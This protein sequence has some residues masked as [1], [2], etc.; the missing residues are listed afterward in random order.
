MNLPK[1][2][3]KNVFFVSLSIIKYRLRIFF[4]FLLL[5]CLKFSAQSQSGSTIYRN[6]CSGCHGNALQGSSA[7]A[8]IKKNWKHGGE[9]NSI[10]KSISNGI[11][12]TEMA[13]FST[14][15]S[16]RQIETVTNY[17][18][19]LQNKTSKAVPA[20]KSLLLNTK[21]YQLKV[22]KLVT[23]GIKTPMAI[24]FVDSNRALIAGYKGEMRW[25]VNGK[26][27]QTPITGLPKTYGVKLVGG[28]L[29][30]ALDPGYSKNGWIY[31]SFAHNNSNSTNKNTP[32]MTKIVRGR[33]HNYKW[34]D[35]QTLFDV[36][37]SL[38]VPNGGVLWGSRFLFDTQGF[39]YFSIGDMNRPDDS[40]ILSKPS[41]KVY[42]IH[43]DGSIP[44]DNPL[45]GKENDLW[46]IYCWGNRNVQG[47]A[48]DPQT[49]LI[50]ASEHGPKGGDEL[51][52]LKKGAN[53]G[54]NLI[55]YGVDYTGK[56]ISNDT[57]KEGMEQPI[58][59]WTPSIAVC[60]LEFV[61]GNRFPEWKNNLLVTALAFQE[62]RR[63]VVDGS[64]VLEQEIL[65]KG[66][67]RVRDVKTGPDGALYVLT[68]GPDEVLR[69]TPE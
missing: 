52:I 41:G 8:L 12:G 4:V 62:L 37:D 42:R 16:G 7:T 48:Q 26:L 19:S 39:L 50:Y 36:N 47:L 49:G 60:A 61:K 46:G 34:V 63:L 6:Y 18:I 31:L 56:I 45:Y 13:K 21:F 3:H 2:L 35:E 32:G 20:V 58:T 23:R 24:E 64:K 33:I 25:M 53:Y 54:W 10:I 5:I 15:L 17:I 9:K 29:D 43:S 14:A 30:I 27:D 44:E 68:N 40:Q 22:E 59:Y 67:G 51:N 1:A 65:M 57:A 69:I 28:Y 55:T 11:P 38:K 66:Q